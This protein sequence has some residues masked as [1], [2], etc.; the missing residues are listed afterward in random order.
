LIGLPGETVKMSKSK[1]FI[2]KQNETDFWELEE[3]YIKDHGTPTE[4]VTILGSDEY[5]VLGDNRYHSYDSEEWGPIKKDD[6][7][8][9]P[10]L[11][12][13]PFNQFGLNPSSYS[14]DK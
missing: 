5:F 1:I 10:S 4:S 13:F 7:L 12:I 3:P 2:K 14:F 8:G 6:I 11:R 9:S